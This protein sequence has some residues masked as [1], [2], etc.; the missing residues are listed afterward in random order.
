MMYY[1]CNERFTVTL[2]PALKR[3]IKIL[4]LIAV[5][6][7]T[8]SALLL[9]TKASAPSYVTEAEFGTL[10][11]TAS[12]SIDGTASDGKAV[13]FSAATPTPTPTPTPTASPTPLPSGTRPTRAN[14]GPRYTMTDMTP[15]QFYAS[16]TCNRQRIVGDVRLEQQWMLSQ[17]FTLT[18]CEITGMFWLYLVGGRALSLA[19]MPTITMSYVDI[20][21]GSILLNAAKWTADYSYIDGG[22][23]WSLDDVWA[24][25][26]TGNAP[27]SISNSVF[28]GPYFTQPTHA[29]PLHVGDYGN[30]Y[31]FTNVAFLQQS[32]PLDNT[33]ITATINFH[34]LDSI[35]DGC[36]FVWENPAQPPAYIT[37]YLD[38]GS[39]SIVRN[40]KFSS[41]PAGYVYSASTYNPTFQNNTDVDTGAPVTGP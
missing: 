37:A 33:G 7:L 32:G 38:A 26:I 24:P 22:S 14:T 4:P 27:I 8:G 15:D 41:G 6:A 9:F 20:N 12:V 19:E 21:G 35:F 10:D 39:G 23:Q 28:Y 1:T 18:D 13:L 25:F 31:R 11:G 2:P 29:E 36:W 34:G 3:S 16:K 5:F 40:S 30:G 17:T